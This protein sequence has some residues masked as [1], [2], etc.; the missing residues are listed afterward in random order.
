MLIYV[1]DIIVAGSFS[2][3]IT[4][5]LKDTFFKRFGWLPIFSCEEVK[6]S[7]DDLILS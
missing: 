3:A 2:E 7:Q 6:K 4:V 1:D 5:L